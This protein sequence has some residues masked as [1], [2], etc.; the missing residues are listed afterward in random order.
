M[1]PTANAHDYELTPHRFLAGDRVRL[2]EPSRRINAASGDYNII[3]LLPERDGQV[4]YRIKSYLEDH[5]RVVKESQ[6][7]KTNA[8]ADAQLRGTVLFEPAKA[9]T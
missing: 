9:R 7:E 3:G 5:C 6:V 1:R 4:Q 2:N 8:R